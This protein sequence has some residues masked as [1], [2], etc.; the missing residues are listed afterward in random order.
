M[1]LIA[2]IKIDDSKSPH[3]SIKLMKKGGFG[4]L[5]LPDKDFFDYKITDSIIE[6]SPYYYYNSSQPWEKTVDITLYIP[7][8]DSTVLINEFDD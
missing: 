8:N 3:L 5:R 1:K 2:L 6:L 4:S 7:D